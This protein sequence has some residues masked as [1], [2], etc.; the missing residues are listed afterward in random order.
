MEKKKN[1]LIFYVGIFL[2]LFIGASAVTRSLQN[3]TFFT[4]LLGQDILKNG[5]RYDEFLTRNTTFTFYN[6][7]W[8]FDIIIATI[9]N[10]Y[11]FNGI[12]FFTLTV[13]SII[14]LLLYLIIT[15]YTK[16]PSLAIVLTFLSIFVISNTLTARA[17]ILSN[18]IF[19][20]QFYCSQE[21]LKTNKKR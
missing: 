5:I 21:L 15:K 16:K 13:A 17:Q 3:D 8:L 9:Y 20:L 19:I 6:I 4:I 14:S 2:A 1:N 7:R 11:S 12:Y 18:I 10:N